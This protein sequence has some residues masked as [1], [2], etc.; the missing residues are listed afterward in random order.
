MKMRSSR[1]P[2]ERCRS[3][4]SNPIPRSVGS[5]ISSSALI[6]VQRTNKKWAEAHL[7]KLLKFNSFPAYRT[8]F[9]ALDLVF[10]APPSVPA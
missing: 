6:V 3:T 2:F 1:P 4:S 7:Q 8:T 5:K 9:R 10:E